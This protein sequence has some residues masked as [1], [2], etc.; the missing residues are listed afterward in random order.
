MNRRSF[1]KKLGIICG[2]T[3]ACPVELLK[4][5]PGPKPGFYDV[6]FEPGW[7]KHLWKNYCAT[8]K[9]ADKRLLDQLRTAFLVHP[10]EP[11]FR[12]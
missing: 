12:W 3:I 8:Y 1:L 4:G 2:A 11:P 6:K 5:E 7:R 10:F 9:P